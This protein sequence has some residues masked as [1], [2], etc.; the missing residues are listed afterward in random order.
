[1]HELTNTIIDTLDH[2][3]SELIIG[4]K[5]NKAAQKRARKALLALEKLGKAYRKASVE[6][7][8]K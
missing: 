1:M 2:L 4:M 8:K 3:K 6:S 7:V 5:P